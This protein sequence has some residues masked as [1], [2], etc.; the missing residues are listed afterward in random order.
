MFVRRSELVLLSLSS[1]L[2]RTLS[3]RDYHH[4]LRMWTREAEH[5]S[6]PPGPDLSRF[7]Q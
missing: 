1:S 7:N 3:R 4:L 2:R 6:G 5:L